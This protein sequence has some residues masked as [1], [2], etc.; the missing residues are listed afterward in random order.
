MA[1]GGG[2]AEDGELGRGDSGDSCCAE[3]GNITLL[4]L[5]ITLLLSYTAGL[6]GI[7]GREGTTQIYTKLSVLFLNPDHSDMPVWLLNSYW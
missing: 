5:L 2:L 7:Q 4:L 6:Q 1:C 3:G